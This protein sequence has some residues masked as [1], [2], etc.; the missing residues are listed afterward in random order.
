MVEE[1]ALRLIRTAVLV[2]LEERPEEAPV[3]HWS[4]GL[5]VLV[6]T[7]LP[8]EDGQDMLWHPFQAVVLLA[9][10]DVE[11]R[12]CCWT[13]PLGQC[14]RVLPEQCSGRPLVIDFLE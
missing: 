11:C 7:S 3:E 13:K 8:Y 1:E 10:E 5:G 14:P 12:R 4:A 9:R 6:V 2:Q